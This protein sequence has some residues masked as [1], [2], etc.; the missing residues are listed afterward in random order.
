M[1][2]AGIP[3]GFALVQTQKSPHS[4]GL[5]YSGNVLQAEG[6]RRVQLVVGMSGIKRFAQVDHEQRGYDAHQAQWRFLGFFSLE[7]GRILGCGRHGLAPD[8]CLSYVDKIGPKG[9]RFQF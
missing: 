1:T 6:I 8:V 2:A 5:L 3:A 4:A 9:L 7:E